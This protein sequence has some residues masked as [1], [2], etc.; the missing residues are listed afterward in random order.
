[1]IRNGRLTKA[2][3]DA[4]DRL[5]PRFCLPYQNEPIDAS[6][7]F[8][9]DAPLWLEIGFG[10]GDALLHMAASCP[11][12]NLLGCEVH[13]PGVGHALIGVEERGLENVRIVQHDAME[14][15][16]HMLAPRSVQRVLL[17]F[18]DPWHKKRHHKR[19]IVQRDF[20][21][22]CARV[23]APDGLLH[24]ATDWADYAEWMLEHIEADNRFENVAGARQE[25]PRP[26]W[27]T[28]T[29]F[30]LRGKRLGHEVTDLLYT[31]RRG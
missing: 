31:R 20:L 22:A 6:T 2:Q 23:L 15:L 25:S 16:E 14:V 12:A 29:R 13:A 17:F 3:G 27:R 7:I 5:A 8:S 1:M 30:E 21:D 10:N 11:E 19:R 18:P 26:E 4:L 9:R 24:C 28:M